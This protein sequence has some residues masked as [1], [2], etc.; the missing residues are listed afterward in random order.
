MMRSSKLYT[1]RAELWVDISH[2]LGLKEKLN[3]GF[4]PNKPCTSSKTNCCCSLRL[5]YLLDKKIRTMIHM[6][7]GEGRVGYLRSHQGGGVGVRNFR[8]QKCLL[9]SIKFIAQ[10]FYQC[11]NEFTLGFPARRKPCTLHP[12]EHDTTAVGCRDGCS[13]QYIIIALGWACPRS[14]QREKK[15]QLK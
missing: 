11:L 14:D 4:K 2:V 8:K 15:D 9:Y 6:N 10:C 7:F 5:L 12:H 1:M 13:R 3:C